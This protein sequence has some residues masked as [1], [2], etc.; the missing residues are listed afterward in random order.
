LGCF[1]I[2][3]ISGVTRSGAEGVI[4]HLKNKHDSVKIEIGA[5]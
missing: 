3:V 4:K 5:G 1:D 2:W